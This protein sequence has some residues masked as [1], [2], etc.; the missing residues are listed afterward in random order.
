MNRDDIAL[1]VS[2]NYDG[3]VAALEKSIAED[4]ALAEQVA[5]E[6]RFEML[7]RDAA[8]DATFC[9]ACGELVHGAR[10]AQSS[11]RCDAC[12][13]AVRPGGYV[14]ERVLVSNAHGRMYVARDA[15]GKQ[16][17]LKELAFVQAPA[18]STLE[19]FEREA[20]FL[21]ALEHVAIPRFVASF[22]E[23]KGVHTRYYLAQEL[24][25][26]KPLDEL[27]DHWYT[28][29]EIVDVARQV[30]TILVYLQS[31]SP[32]VIHRDIKPANLVRRGDGSIALVDFGAAYVHGSTA[33]VTTIGTFGYMPVEQLAGIVDATTDVFALG[34]SLLYLLTRQEPWRLQQQKTTLNVSAPLR[35][36]IDKLVA[37]DPRDR[38]G[39]AKDALAALD[40]RDELVVKKPK[41][42]QRPWMRTAIIAATASV[43]SAGGLGVYKMAT[44][45]EDPVKAT[46]TY[47]ASM[48]A[49]LRLALPEGVTAELYVDDKKLQAVKNG[50][51]IPVSAGMRKVKLL[52]PSG[53][54]CEQA[55]QLPPDK[56]TT[57]ECSMPVSSPN[58]PAE[59]RLDVDRQVSWTYSKKPL[60]DVLI[61]AAKACGV[62]V[63]VSDD[64]QT[65]ITA[66]LAN[67]PCNQALESI[68]ESNG[69][70]Y[71]YDK[72]QKLVRIGA[73]RQLDVEAAEKQARPPSL[74]PRLP[75]GAKLS[76][77]FKDAP[78]RDVLQILIGSQGDKLNLILPDH[79]DGKIT[80]RLKE[81]AF[82][83]AFESILEAKGLWYRYREAGKIIRVAPRR[84]L[85]VEDA[86][87][88]A[89]KGG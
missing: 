70:W 50:L 66:Q 33:G 3:D 46:T 73:R 82:R 35:A 30:L 38:F 77:D 23:G 88:R 2:G 44:R 69:L 63:V 22:E 75:A 42:R 31:L 27:D 76:L 32:M 55:V 52:G 9:A 78:L 62:S 13:A 51:E 67:A 6:A 19:A 36:F 74:Y 48:I 29:A 53:A 18:V 54:R 21:R 5:D 34:S 20:K 71:V 14:V 40:N 58:P 45:R 43:L 25:A 28:E 57:I 26:G 7:L 89:R 61:E 15:D 10:A 11:E 1:Y 80:I 41:Q 16:V 65:T 56:V 17:A 47:P 68:L 37:P 12:G 64:L 72:D 39:S 81:V 83:D 86:E 4:S 8:A 84:Q 49:T 60:H 87:D 59:V 85:D 79:I 24:V